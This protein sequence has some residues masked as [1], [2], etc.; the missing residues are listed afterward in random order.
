MGK[1]KAF[2]KLPPV[3][4]LR[5]R[6]L[7][8]ILMKMG[9]LSR[10][11]VHECLE[12]QKK[13]GGSVRI[14]QIFLE[15]GL[16]EEMQLQV[17][18][19]AKRGMEYGSIEGIDIAADIIEK[20]PAQ[21]AKTYHILPIAYSKE[22][23]ELTVALDNVDNFRATDDLRTLMG[24]NVVAKMTDRESLE[25]ALTKYYE[26][27]QD[28]N[29]TELIDEIQSDAFLAEFDGRNT[30]IDLDELK[31]LSESNPVK[32]L[33]NLVLLQ[34]IRDKASDIHFEPFE[35]EYKMRYRIDGVLYEMIPPPK[36]I[37]AALS[38]RIKVMANL[39]IAERR[40][41]Q[42]GRISLTVQGNPV[43]LRVS[44]LP[45]M[46]GESVVLRV[47]D[48]SQ[49]SFDLEKLGL[50]PNEIKTFRQLINKPN[51]II[52]VT[53]PTGCGKTTT[54]YSAL[55]ELNTID[56]KVITTEDPVEYDMDGMI[57]V[58][59]KPDIGLT[60][61]RCLRSILRQDP[62]IILVGEIR[63][64][65]TA[66]IAAQASLTGHLVFTTLHTNDSPST[67]ARLLDLGVEPFLLTATI[68]G[69]VGQRLV[70]RICSNCKM[71]FEPD[72][73]QLR[74]LRLTE[75]DI[76]GKKFYYG[77]GCSK[78]NGTGYK[79]RIG[80]FEIMVFNEEIRELVMERASTNVLRLAA[81]KAGMGQLRDC[82]LAAI[83]DGITTIDEISKET[84]ME[85]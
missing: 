39:D 48:R 81:Q 21:M 8:R 16:V 12:I 50:R 38:S 76:K 2:E 82:G 17:A 84:M 78:C 29:I 79:G 63:D 42:D 54:L 55:N 83:Y 41:P 13:R 18:L 15:L 53:G 28:D 72:E 24:F 5:G 64:L 51:G 77:R 45:T 40:L 33:L 30:S 69:I 6:P 31:E 46:F 9:V 47:L 7:G 70:R 10:E 19:A 20:V 71:A 37:A 44:V 26:T 32:K 67:I 34:A 58:Q 36:Y 52:I 27:K 11:K 3:E 22:K 43:D 25:S 59:M 23:N 35:N 57:Q 61:A 74:E 66:E 75:E 62:D 73:A 14:G 68:E 49:V 65:E 85:D 1:T 60:F 4:Q 56:T 80:I